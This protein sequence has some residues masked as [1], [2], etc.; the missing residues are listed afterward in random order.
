MKL[1]IY[2]YTFSIVI[3]FC[4]R[5]YAQMA[6]DIQWQKTYGGKGDDRFLDEVTT[7]DGGY[8]FF[9]YTNSNSGDLKDNHGDYD[10]WLVHTDS[11]GHLLWQKLYGGSKGD[12][13]AG[14]SLTND[15]GYI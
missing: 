3:F 5:A 4:L 6:P 15:G 9:G 13:A 2:T 7:S 10:L 1:S 11:S 12:Y 8:T 14:M